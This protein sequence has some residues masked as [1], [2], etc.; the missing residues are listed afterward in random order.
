M[1]RIKTILVSMLILCLTPMYAFAIDPAENNTSEE[2]EYTVLFWTEKSDYNEKATNLRDKYE[3]ISTK[4]FTGKIGSTPNLANVDIKDVPFPDLDKERLEK[5]YNGDT[6][7][8]DRYL[9]LNK[10]YEFNKDLTNKEN[11]SKATKAAKTIS[12]S[13]KTVYNIYF[14]RT[15][16]DLYFTKWNGGG[17]NDPTYFHPTYIKDEKI[18]GESGK[19]Y[20]FKARFNQVMSGWPDDAQM[21]KGFEPGSNSLGY[22]KNTGVEGS[23]GNIHLDTPP[24]RLN[25]NEFL[26]FD[27]YENIGG[28]T[29]K[30]DAGNG[31]VIDAN[32]DSRYKDKPF[33][34][35]SFGV[36]SQNN[37]IPHHMDFLMDGFK[38]GE[39]YF[40]YNLFRTKADTESYTYQHK[41]PKI[42]GFTAKYSSKLTKKYK[43]EEIDELN[44]ERQKITPFPDEEVLNA[45][46]FGVNKGEISF[47][48]AF[49]NDSDEFGD[50][51]D[52]LAPFKENGYIRFEY[53]RN[54]YKL[55]LNND[56]LNVKA[57]S[58]Y[59][60]GKDQLDVFYDYPL[61]N[62]NLDTTNIPEKPTWALDNFKFQGWCLDPIGKNLVKYGNE[63]MPDHQYVLYA[64]WAPDAVETI[65]DKKITK[66]KLQKLFEEDKT[67][68]VEKI[69][70]LEEPDVSKP[71]LSE[72]QVIVEF[73]DGTKL[74]TEEIPFIVEVD[75]KLPLSLIEDIAI[76]THKDEI[77]LPFKTIKRETKDLEIG[78]TRVIK[79]GELGKKV[80]TTITVGVNGEPKVTEEIVKEPVDEIIEVGTKK[81]IPATPIEDIATKVAKTE[82]V[83]PYKTVYVANAALK[84]GETEVFQEGRDGKK[85]IT[86]TSKVVD[87]KRVEEKTEKVIS[88]ATPKIVSVGYR[89]INT[90]EIPYNTIKKETKDLKV[91]ET[92]VIQ[93]GVKG[94][95]KTTTI[96]EVDKDTGELSSPKD[97]VKTTDAVD[98]IIL[99]G[100]RVEK[101]WTEI[102]DIATKVTK[103][104]EKIPAE[105][106]YESD[107]S[108]E[109]EE[110]KIIDKPVDGEK[111]ITTT[112]YVENGT[113]KEK[114][115]E[116]VITEPKNGK[117][118][119][120]NKKVVID[121]DKTITTIYKVDPKTGKLYDPKISISAPAKPIEDIAKKVTKVIEKI[122]AKIVYITDESL[123]F[124][125]KQE[126]TP[127]QDGEKEVTI[128]SYVKDGKRTEERTEKITKEKQD[129]VVK[130]G[131]KEVIKDGDKTITKIYEVDPKT[132]ELSNPKISISVPA[133][134]IEDIATKTTSKEVE[135]PYETKNKPNEDLYE[136][137]SKVIQ[138]GKPG[139]K[140]VTTKTVSGKEVIEEK[141]IEEPTPEIIAV[142][143]K[144][145]VEETKQTAI[146]K[147]TEQT[148]SQSAPQTNVDDNTQIYVLLFVM[149][150]LLAFLI[151]R[152][153]KNLNK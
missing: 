75:T 100:T 57:D 10:F 151:G 68:E 28:Y 147:P 134:T 5:I 137:T 6:F 128:T 27:K 116:K 97:D 80:I 86:T 45:W 15:V 35:I 99:I 76:K 18:V 122:I 13:G 55:R 21:T 43:A 84:Y 152:G 11:L 126:K 118:K 22:F 94:E 146:N 143:T 34:M 19:P 82:E 33:T 24:Y 3:Y 121:G 61:K 119:I 139:K 81:V 117:T 79:K 130:V 145:K 87:G 71:G 77:D 138:K 112:S 62:L 90:E 102:E 51:I 41:A 38:P 125:E 44:N 142:G 65:V 98:E 48:N 96:Y 4:K 56:P 144:K 91:G 14:N 109:F 40:D 95:K 70:V 60:D 83:I 54:K 150:S 49:L 32:T 148:K 7:Y 149:S 1:R 89:K 108:L 103:V 105:I 20:H 133:K 42:K 64:K 66:D 113:R 50:P 2:A 85:E 9:F 59:T 141:V 120:G 25:A 101:P 140:I 104:N 12:K 106:I 110:E 123:P 37:S 58:E 17:D 53:S 23:G 29:T 129:S 52:G 114:S 63:K 67:K 136:G 26:D 111:V 153:K 93:R 115:E 46:G 31:V 135:I 47:M 39:K 107:D 78:Q 124:G 16:Y 72:M 30:L 88:K 69:T 127:G 8:G 92:K 73:K 36:Q 132:G 74:G 131:N